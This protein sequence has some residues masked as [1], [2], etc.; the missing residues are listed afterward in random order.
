MQRAGLI[1]ICGLLLGVPYYRAACENQ[2]SDVETTICM[3]LAPIPPPPIPTPDQEFAVSY[4]NSILGI[5]RE[6]LG[7]G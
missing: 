6:E 5:I 1:G 4:A 3:R 7:C 2:L